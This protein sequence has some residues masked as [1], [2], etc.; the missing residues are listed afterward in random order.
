MH[1]PKS[2]T[3]QSDALS[4]NYQLNTTHY[5]QQHTYRV[6][7]EPP[8]D[9]GSGGYVKWFTNGEYIYGIKGSVL[10]FMQTEIPNVSTLTA[11]MQQFLMAMTKHI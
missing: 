9:T 7:W 8:D 10:D 4:A 6:E 3:Y 5:K 1:S 2:L 11:K